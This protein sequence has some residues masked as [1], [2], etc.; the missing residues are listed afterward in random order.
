[1]DLYCEKRLL[2]CFFSSFFFILSHFNCNDCS[3]FEMVLDCLVVVLVTSMDLSV[4]HDPY[5]K[6][7][8]FC[9][10]IPY[11]L[12]WKSNIILHCKVNGPCFYIILT[13]FEWTSLNELLLQSLQ[14]KWLKMKK[15]LEKKHN[16]RRFSQ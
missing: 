11:P 14:L 8:I 7:M 12:L 4:S 10:L 5:F 1:M 16:K 9:I 2:L 15:K 6:N 13:Q 3:N